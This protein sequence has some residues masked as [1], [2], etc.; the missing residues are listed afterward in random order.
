MFSYIDKIIEYNNKYYILDKSSLRTVVSF[1]KDGTPDTKY[2]RI[3]QG[4]GEY[5]F[6]WDYGHRRN[7][8]ICVGYKFKKVIHYNESGNS[9][10]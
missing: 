1:K 6:P 9:Y 4:P 8:G 3:G 5:V 2:G 10:R 7:W